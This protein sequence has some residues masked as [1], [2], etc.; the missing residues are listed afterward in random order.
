MS[1]R[2]SCRNERS[3]DGLVELP[4][5]TGLISPI[6]T[7]WL[8]HCKS[9]IH[10]LAVCSVVGAV[11]WHGLNLSLCDPNSILT[12]SVWLRVCCICIASVLQV[13]TTQRRS[14]PATGLH[15]DSDLTVSRV[16][17]RW[18]LQLLKLLLQQNSIS[19]YPKCI[20]AF[21][22]LVVIRESIPTPLQ[23]YFIVYVD[24]LW[25]LSSGEESEKRQHTLFLES[26]QCVLE[27]WGIECCHGNC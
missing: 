23:S 13:S 6:Y 12:P 20:R 3:G 22:S 1:C 21:I 18:L 15:G 8:Y 14:G 27:W 16:T 5:Y 26:L 17:N 2:W 11:S 9:H 7:I 24:F 4:E 10:E 25:G 19:C